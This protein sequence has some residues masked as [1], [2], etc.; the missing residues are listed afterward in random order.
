MEAL[1]PLAGGFVLAAL[2]LLC[3]GCAGLP[4]LGAALPPPPDAAVGAAI[5][6]GYPWA[7]R[8]CIELVRDPQ[9]RAV[10]VA[11]AREALS[12]ALELYDASVDAELAERSPRPEGAVTR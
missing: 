3:S 5:I 2:A 12:S 8:A 1:T 7:T 6:V 11:V 9:E 10:C 4:G